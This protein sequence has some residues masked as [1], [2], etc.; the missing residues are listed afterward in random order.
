MAPPVSV[1]VPVRDGARTIPALLASL[2]RQTLPADRFEIV[3]VDNASRDETAELARDAGAIVI[4][5]PVANRALARNRGVQAASGELLAFVDADCVA[6]PQW[7][8]SILRCSPAAPLMA[9]PVRLTTND[10]PN[11]VERF[12][13]LWRFAQEHWV[14]QGWA[15]T[16]NLAVWREAFERVGGFDPAYRHYSEDAD[17]CVR[18]KRAGLELGYCPDA[19]VCHAGEDR[20]WPMLRR[21]FFHGYGSSQAVRRI[22][23]GH[24]AW[25]HPGPLLDARGAMALIGIQP[26]TLGRR[27]RRRIR[28]LARLAYGAR[29]LGS[30]WSTLRRAR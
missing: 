23:V 5:E 1:V 4:Q 11:P 2:A 3:V 17:F 13:R 18:C 20:L 10:P 26:D 29:L 7:L 27:E 21:A 12:E 30:V 6:E 8:E 22:G 28:E 24:Q 19:T 25:R 14:Q 16:A 15:V 9:G